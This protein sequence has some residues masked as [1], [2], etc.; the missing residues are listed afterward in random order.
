VTEYIS[1]RIFRVWSFNPTHRQ[2]ILRSNPDT[3]DDGALRIEVY[4][5]NVAYMALQPIMRGVAIRL[6]S[7]DERASI[8][9]RFDVPAEEREFIYLVTDTAPVSFVVSGQPTWRQAERRV[10]DP[11]LFDFSQPWPPT[12][13]IEWG[14]VG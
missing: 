6:A 1:N 4:F 12:D 13:S 7:K 11:S 3:R 8:G 2:L 9:H 5:G 10:D 14:A